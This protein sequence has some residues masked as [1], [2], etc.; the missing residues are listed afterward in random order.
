MTSSTKALGYELETHSNPSK[1]TH[2]PQNYFSSD[3]RIPPLKGRYSET[4]TPLAQHPLRLDVITPLVTP[5][6]HPSG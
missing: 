4:T 3:S 6:E 1:D 5:L 2:S